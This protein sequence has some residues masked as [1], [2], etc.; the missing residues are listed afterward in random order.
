VGKLLW[1]YVLVVISAVSF[2]LIPIFAVYAYDSGV[3]T[4]TLLLLR[5]A[6][7]TIFFFGYLFI[8]R[9]F[10]KI[11]KQQ[12]LSL[13]IL[14]G[15]LYTMQS[16]FYFSSVKYIPAS[17]AALMF[18]IYPIIVAILSFF[19]NKERLSK[20]LVMSIILSFMGIMLVLGTPSG[21]INPIGILFAIGAAVVYSLYILLGDKVTKQLPPLITTAYISLFCSLSF[22]LVGTTTQTLQMKFSGKGWIIVLG[23]AFFCSIVAMFTFF[24]GMNILGPTKASILSMVEPV[25]TI[26][27]STIFLNE[28]MSGLQLTG[29]TIVLVGAIFVI[30]AREKRQSPSDNYVSKTG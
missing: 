4:I 15:L 28:K 29:G 19:V 13:F 30:L 9:K 20:G 24:A 11:T 3:N 14:G 6:I 1:G 8:K 16:T 26:V 27:L 7:A 10:V 22:L 12:V 2:S 18:Y 21:E 5:F 17:L 25:S 23:V